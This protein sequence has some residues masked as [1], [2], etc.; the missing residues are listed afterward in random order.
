MARYPKLPSDY[1]GVIVSRQSVLP[2][3]ID[4]NGHMNVA[5][6]VLAFDLAID[7]LWLQLGLTEE[8]RESSGCSTFAAECHVRYLSELHEGDAF[9]IT[10]QIVASDDKRLHQ[11]QRMYSANTGALSASCEWMNLHV[12]LTTRKVAPWPQSVRE[13]IENFAQGH[14][15]A[16]RPE[17]LGSVI[18]MRR[19]AL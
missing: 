5:Y 10:A 18:G 8:Y 13:A 11:F 6:Y 4:F 9:F 15:G 7:G 12:D 2:E 19:P 17:G 16:E 3:W 14:R 1:E